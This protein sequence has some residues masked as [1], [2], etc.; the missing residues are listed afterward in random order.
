MSPP[1]EESKK[2]INVD[3]EIDNNARERSPII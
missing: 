1:K 2:P 3:I